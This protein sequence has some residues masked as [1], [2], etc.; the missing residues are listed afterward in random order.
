[1]S[2]SRSILIRLRLA[3]ILAW[4]F[5]VVAAVS[6][7]SHQEPAP[8]SPEA[9]S[10]APSPARATAVTPV[11]REVW[12][13]SSM[14][15]ARMGYSRT[16]VTPLV[17]NGRPL[18]RVEQ[19]GRMTVRRFDTTLEMD[20]HFSCLETPRATCRDF[21]WAPRWWLRASRP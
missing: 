13:I 3:G 12:E 21:P 16:T 6:G 17:R 20:L 11:E 8:A 14:G 4:M 15:N 10:S 1:M 2:P 19:T 5:Y 9:S 18:V 7:C